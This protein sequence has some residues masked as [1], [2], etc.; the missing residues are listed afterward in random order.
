[1]VSV[2]ASG[3][4]F[5]HFCIVTWREEHRN[6]ALWT[7]TQTATRSNPVGEEDWC[8]RTDKRWFLVCIPLSPLRKNIVYNSIVSLNV[9]LV[10]IIDTNM[11]FTIKCLVCIFQEDANFHWDL[12]LCQGVSKNQSFLVT[13][14]FYIELHRVMSGY[15]QK[16]LFEPW[17]M[18]QL[19][20]PQW[21]KRPRWQ[22]LV[23]QLFY[24]HN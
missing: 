24:N 3:V 22:E 23:Q 13:F 14:T 6:I 9:Y 19:F 1:M 21:V 15:I 16:L 17:Q 5:T 10:G 8:C 20:W 4:S 11:D 18:L 2:P 7:A 12:C